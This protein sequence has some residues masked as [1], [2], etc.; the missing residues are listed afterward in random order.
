VL[1][2]GDIKKPDDEKLKACFEIIVKQ[3]EQDKGKTLKAVK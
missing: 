1:G 3:S 2:G